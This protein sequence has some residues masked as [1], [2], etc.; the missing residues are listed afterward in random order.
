MVNLSFDNPCIALCK[1]SRILQVFNEFFLL[2]TQCSN[3]GIVGLLCRSIR[4]TDTTCYN[5][6]PQIAAAQ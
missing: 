6:T 2:I 1:L 4:V 3:T 5:T